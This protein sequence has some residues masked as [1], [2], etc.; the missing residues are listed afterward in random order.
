[1]RLTRSTSSK[2]HRHGKMLDEWKQQ[3]VDF[4]LNNFRVKLFSWFL[5]ST[6]INNT[7]KSQL[8]NTPQLQRVNSHIYSYDQHHCTFFIL[9]IRRER[10]T[11]VCEMHRIKKILFASVY[12]IVHNNTEQ[13]QR[14]YR[15]DT[16]AR[17]SRGY[18]LWFWYCGRWMCGWRWSQ[19]V[20]L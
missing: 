8:L 19:Q 15:I 7:E 9:F 13:Q 18:S 17:F 16:H 3:F 6:T 12:K 2:Q 11:N 5:T 14:I 1:M 4:Y 10:A 20:K